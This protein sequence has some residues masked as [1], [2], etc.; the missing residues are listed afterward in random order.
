VSA[1][2]STS[3]AGV[4]A[5]PG[6]AFHGALVALAERARMVF[7][8]GL[9]GTG[10][11]LCIHQLAHLAHARGRR[12]FL[13]Q[14]DVAR[15]PFE[16]H[17]AGRAYP[18]DRGVTH[19]VIRLAVGRWAREA[20]AR[21]SGEHPGLEALLIGE[22]P[23]VGNRLVELARSVADAAEPLLAAP[24]ARFVVPVPSLAV[25][26]HIEAER[27]RR[28][29][30]PL[31]EREREDAPPEVMRDLWRQLRAAAVT[32]G[33]APPT[34]DPDPPYDPDTYAAVYLAVLG[35][36]HRERLALDAILPTSSLSPYDVRSPRTDLTPDPG[37][38]PRFIT[39][40]AASAP[41]PT[42]LRIHLDHWYR[43]TGVT[44]G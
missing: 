15:P 39:E 42:A 6:S 1:P 8:A 25:R 38:I 40:A 23:L 11:S 18:I 5:P 10:K 14:W 20:I 43:N 30:A 32:L 35:N 33:L 28:A 31:H 37:D 24:S 41:D 7:L 9:P 4:I 3:A 21:W 29:A 12:I 36:R 19:G 13:L 2:A 17:P 26:A 16:A 27:V 22:T 34:S 44:R